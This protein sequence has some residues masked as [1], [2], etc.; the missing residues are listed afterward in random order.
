MNSKFDNSQEIEAGYYLSAVITH[1]LDPPSEDDDHQPNPE[2]LTSHCFVPDH[3]INQAG[4][5][6]P[7]QKAYRIPVFYF[8]FKN[9]RY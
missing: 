8:F 9:R 1:I 6:D 5:P 7:R 4:T 3:H 2:H